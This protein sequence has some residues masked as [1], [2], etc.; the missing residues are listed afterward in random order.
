MRSMAVFILLASALSFGQA[1][2]SVPA[3]AYVPRYQIVCVKAQQQNVGGSQ[4]AFDTVFLLDT[5]TGKIWEYDGFSSKFNADGSKTAF[6]ARFTRVFTDDLSGPPA[7]Y[8]NVVY[9]I[10]KPEV[11]QV[12]L[13]AAGLVPAN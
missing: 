13:P 2:K 12:A 9:T 10:P 5:E 1:V 6:P 7:D 3:P 4:S 8:A 11:K